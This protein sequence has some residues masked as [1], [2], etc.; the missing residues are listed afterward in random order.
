MSLLNSA[1]KSET[2]ST[3]SA[4]SIFYDFYLKLK[5][6]KAAPVRKAIENFFKDKLPTMIKTKCSREEQGAQV[7][8]L[9]SE[10]TDLFVDAFPP[11]DG[12][13]MAQRELYGEGIENCV[14]KNLY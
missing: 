2:T 10:M 4:Q 14:M 3:Q 12:D 9:M 7:Q 1:S 5:S 6:D 8:D 13:Q 11:T